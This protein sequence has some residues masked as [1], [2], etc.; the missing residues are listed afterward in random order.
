MNL[1]NTA[2][3]FVLCVTS[4]IAA[5]AT[6][7]SG[8]FSI[9]GTSVA[10]NG[11]MLSFSPN[12]INVGAANTLYGSF[13]SLLT[14][15]EGGTISSPINYASY[16][17]NSS[18]LN[19]SNGAS[20]VTFTLSSISEVTSGIFGNFTGTG[21]ISTNVAGFDPTVGNLYFTT[22][23]NGVTTFSATALTPSAV[24]EPSTLT[25]F[26]TGILGLAGL[27]KRRLMA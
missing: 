19:F 4:A 24:P 15:G 14:A 17:P 13:S 11:S 10:D 21:L 27:V 23:G 25:L 12:T 18:A 8:Q 9:T 2:A 26:G 6:P 1:R 5:H 16:V 20:T 22:Q 7:I 3:V